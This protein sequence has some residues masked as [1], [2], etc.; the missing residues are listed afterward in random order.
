M[1]GDDAGQELEVLRRST[2]FGGVLELVF[3]ACS[4]DVARLDR[5]LRRVVGEGDGVRDRL[6]D[7]TR[8]TGCARYVAPPVEAFS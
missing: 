1:I 5:T 4:P 8:S 6:A 2:A 7:L 3:L